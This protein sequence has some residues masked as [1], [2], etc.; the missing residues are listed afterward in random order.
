[1]AGALALAAGLYYGGQ[2]IAPTITAA[3]SAYS[4]QLAMQESQKSRDWQERMSNTAHQREVKDLR[5]AGLNPI[6]SATGGQGAS[7]PSGA[8]A[9]IPDFGKVGESYNQ[10]KNNSQQGKQINSNVKLQGIQEAKTA[11]EV[12]NLDQDTS[13]KIIQGGLMNE[14]IAQTQQDTAL[15]GI[16]TKLAQKDLDYYD[17]KTLTDMQTQIITANAQKASADAANTSAKAAV[18]NAATGRTQ[19]GIAQQNANS[20]SLTAKENAKNQQQHRKWYGYE[21]VPQIFRDTAIG[22]GAA[23]AAKNA[24]PKKGNKVGF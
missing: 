16:Q 24:F 4:A 15:K 1:M 9:Q 10:S 11:S 14:Q 6:L 18:Q 3:G 19:A 5:A 7:T 23:G 17:R 2:A 20:I 21:K 22:V 8:M 13:N 12:H